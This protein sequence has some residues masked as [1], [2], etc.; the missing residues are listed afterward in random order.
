MESMPLLQRLWKD[1]LS[2]GSK[3]DNLLELAESPIDILIV[4]ENGNPLE[5]G[6]RERR[7]FEG[8]WIFKKDDT[9]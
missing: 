1:I 6:D 7:F 2:T 9:K 5:T 4:D 8:S 3:K